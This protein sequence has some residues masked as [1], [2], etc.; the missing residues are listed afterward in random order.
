[1]DL[2]KTLLFGYVSYVT[3]IYDINDTTNTFD[4]DGASQNVAIENF[5]DGF[6]DFTE[7]NPFGDPSETY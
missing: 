2:L 3:K 5:A 7:N 4:T 1:M 6:I